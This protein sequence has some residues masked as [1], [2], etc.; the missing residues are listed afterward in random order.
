MPGEK[1]ATVQREEAWVIPPIAEF[2]EVAR[3][4]IP[5]SREPERATT[6]R[7]APAEEKSESASLPKRAPEARHFYGS[8][9]QGKNNKGRL[10]NLGIGH[11]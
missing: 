5:R 9:T 11:W 6:K 1:L 7:T 2:E 4:A 10:V 3:G 8:L